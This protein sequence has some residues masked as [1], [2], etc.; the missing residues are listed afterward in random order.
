MLP[1]RKRFW[2]TLSLVLLFSLIIA[3]CGGDDDNK[4]DDDNNDNPTTQ[5]NADDASS[6]TPEI[7]PLANSDLL[8]L[9]LTET[10]AFE[11]GATFL[12]PRVNWFLFD[13]ET[14]QEGVVLAFQGGEERAANGVVL[15]QEDLAVSVPDAASLEDVIRGY[16]AQSP[17]WPS[18]SIDGVLMTE[19]TTPDARQMLFTTFADQSNN[20]VLIIAVDL[21]NDNRGLMYFTSTSESLAADI[22]EA[23]L[24][25]AETFAG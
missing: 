13:D 4:D 3:A 18:V 25:I 5:S 12:Y 24:Q 17:L 19:R 16:V 14:V 21:G 11:S 20:E 10:Y 9:D 7:D 8:P 1:I 15:D 23:L 2:L 22:K 6:N